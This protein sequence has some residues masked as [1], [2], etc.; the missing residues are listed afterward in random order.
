MGAAIQRGILLALQI[1]EENIAYKLHTN[2]LTTELIGD[3]NN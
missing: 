3:Y 2:T 1:C